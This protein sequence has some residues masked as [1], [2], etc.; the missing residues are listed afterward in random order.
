MTMNLLFCATVYKCLA[1]RTS[2]ITSQQIAHRFKK[3]HAHYDDN[4]SVQQKLAQ[5]LIVLIKN[6]PL[7]KKYPSVLEIGCGTG[8]LTKQFLKDCA[9]DELHLND[10]Y[11]DIKNNHIHHQNITYLIGDIQELDLTN[12]YFDLILSSSVL[13]WIYPLDKLLNKLHQ[14]LNDNG[15]LLFSSFLKD[16][17]WQIRHLTG[18]GLDYYDCNALKTILEH[19]GFKIL[20]CQE[21]HHERLFDTPYEILKHLKHTGVTANNTGFQ[22]NKQRLNAFNDGY[23]DLSLN[24]NG[25]IVYPLTYHSV[26]ILAQKANHNDI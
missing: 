16:N 24:L 25:Q 3:S 2:M 19:S 4:A 14:Q 12:S 22:W 18:Q 15:Y 26:I 1:Q 20:H 6:H 17:L 9:C 8:Y 13:Q 23:Q 11:D 10:L 7:P 21:N 5:E